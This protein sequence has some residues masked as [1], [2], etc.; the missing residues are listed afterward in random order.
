MT[1]ILLKVVLDIYNHTLLTVNDKK[2]TLQKRCA[3]VHLFTLTN[4]SGIESDISL[5]DM[6]YFAKFTNEKI[7][8]DY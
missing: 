5:Q 4:T 6:I 3:Y 8:C 7:N 1:Q 2:K